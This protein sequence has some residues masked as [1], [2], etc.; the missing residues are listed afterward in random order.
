M[1][2]RQVWVAGPVISAAREDTQAEAD[3]VFLHVS[4]NIRPH[5]RPILAIEQAW[6]EAVAFRCGN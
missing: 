3:P 1:R 4:L 6:V 2:A 5:A